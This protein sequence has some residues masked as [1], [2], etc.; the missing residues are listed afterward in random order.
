MKIND[1]LL[2][3]IAEFRVFEGIIDIDDIGVVL[4][5]ET[6]STYTVNETEDLILDHFHHVR[7]LVRDGDLLNRHC[8]VRFP[9]SSQLYL[10]V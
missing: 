8:P 1:L 2:Y 5:D 3:D 7:T 9:V 6:Q 10:P 4:Q